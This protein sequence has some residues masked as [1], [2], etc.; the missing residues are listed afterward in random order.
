M[1]EAM[2]P[3]QAEAEPVGVRATLAPEELAPY[4]PQLEILECLGRGGMGVVYKAR[5]KSL[6]RLVALKLL[7]P[8]RGNDPGFAGRFQ[9]EAQ[10][11]AKLNHP[12]I[13]TVYDFGLAG[14]FYFLLMEF[15][16]GMNLRQLLQAERIQ[17]REALAIVPQ[18]CDALQYAHDAGI[19][20]RD[21]KP[22]NILL[23]R[24][25]HVKVADFGLAKII[26]CPTA[27]GLSEVSGPSGVYSV[28]P[29]A[30]E[31]SKV[32][33]T[34]QYMAPE[35]IEHPASVDHRADIYSLGVV[36][37]QML[38]G[39]LPK[40]D[41]VPPSKK[42]VIDVRL[43][44]VVLRALEKRPDLRYQQVSDVKTVVENIVASSGRPVA[45]NQKPECESHIS[46]SPRFDASEQKE[47]DHMKD[48]R[49]SFTAQSVQTHFLIIAVTW[50][51]GY[52]LSIIG[53]FL[54]KAGELLLGLIWIPAIIVMTVFCCILLY[55]QWS[56]LQGHGARIT[57][58]KAV[59][60]GFIPVFCFYWWFVAWAGLATD[61]NKYLKSLGITSTR[62]SFGL[63]V[64]DCIIAIL[65]CT[66]GL[67]PKV[68]AIFTVPLMII[69]FI[70]VVQQ[71][72]CVLAIL[73]ERTGRS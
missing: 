8:E 68:G 32:V 35:Q 31:A 55:R 24:R 36:F 47:S 63:A 60:F 52:P 4:F 71:R 18:I 56:L 14:G 16:D 64:T 48:E 26:R 42:V 2:K 15:V 66:I 6:N 44:E 70:L 19:V 37:Y 72:D 30:S 7:A 21:I 22:E 73:H 20:H 1:A 65:A 46:R 11:L 12:A 69:G 28:R 10:A 25:G 50:W 5:Q 27:S 43:D 13:V 59:G 61:T 41:F 57:P 62:M 54:P 9:R 45:G 49:P 39:E 17:A 33:G 23:D 38:T 67:I 51:I 40:G 3:S 29:D 53:E 58:G 34:P